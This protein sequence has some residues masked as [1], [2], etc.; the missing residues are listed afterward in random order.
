[1]AAKKFPL[2]I[3]KTLDDISWTAFF[4]YYIEGITQDTTAMLKEELGYD[5]QQLVKWLHKYARN[6]MDLSE[7]R[8]EFQDMPEDFRN[9]YTSKQLK[10]VGLITKQVATKSG[11]G[12][13]QAKQTPAKKRKIE[14]R[15]EPTRS[16]KATPAPADRRRMPWRSAAEPAQQEDYYKTPNRDKRK[17]VKV[18]RSKKLGVDRRT[19]KQR[20][21]RPGTL[22]LRQIRHFQGTTHQIMAKTAVRR[23]A[24]EL[25]QKVQIE[26]FMDPVYY[27][28]LY[29][30]TQ[31]ANLPEKLQPHVTYYRMAPGAVKA[32]IEA[33]EAYIISLM[34][35]GYLVSLHCKRETLQPQ[36]I[37]LARKIR[38]DTER[39]DRMQTKAEK[40]EE[41]A[42]RQRAL[43]ELK[44][45]RNALAARRARRISSSSSSDDNE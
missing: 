2:I 8:T 23:I 1:M 35:D 32:L 25:L 22:A 11:G 37:K 40:E 6:N 34:H 18:Y 28:K 3:T 16:K 7:Y 9:Q 20:R 12:R 5:A 45:K 33:S 26:R 19:G 42:A 27:S 30:S 44:A 15:T 41:K 14:P 39:F 4:R 31:F 24:Q 10:D 17:P 21:Y 13:S 43:D 38:G 29:E 36:D